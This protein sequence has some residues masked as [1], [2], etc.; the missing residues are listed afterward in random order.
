MRPKLF[1]LLAVPVLA[2]VGCSTA[3]PAPAPAEAS[4]ASAS[5][6]PTSVDE[7]KLDTDEATKAEFQFVRLA[8]ASLSQNGLP[9]IDREKL[10]SA[11]HKF[12]DSGKP[13]NLT[14]SDF[15]NDYIDNLAINGTCEQLKKD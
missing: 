15:A 13:M 9:E 5:P 11:L 6:K 7:I 1:A 3:E 14:A 12:C 4:S 2:L 10:I 8:Q